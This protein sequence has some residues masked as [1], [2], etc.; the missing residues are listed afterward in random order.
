MGLGFR[1]P[2]HFAPQ[3][4]RA[5]GHSKALAAGADEGPPTRD[6]LEARKLTRGLDFR[7]QG[8]LMPLRLK[9]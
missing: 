4:P 1:A 2:G 5:W 7:A 8:I 3:G 9:P 6:T